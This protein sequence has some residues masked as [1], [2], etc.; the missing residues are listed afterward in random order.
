MVECERG[1]RRFV[2]SAALSQ[3]FDT[4]HHNA[5]RPSE[6]ERQL[7]VEKE[8]DTYKATVYYAQ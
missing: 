7:A 6:L 8:L 2:S 4:K 1:H 5:Q 3:H